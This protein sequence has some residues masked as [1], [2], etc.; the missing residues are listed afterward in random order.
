MVMVMFMCAPQCNPLLF[1]YRERMALW[2]LSVMSTYR[3]CPV[4]TTL[5]NLALNI[6]LN[7]LSANDSS[8]VGRHSLVPFAKVNSKFGVTKM[9]LGG[10][11]ED[12]QGSIL[13]F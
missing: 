12:L 8:V 4:A 3:F 1:S 6:I 10:N 5:A 13:R 7:L 2:K 11:D 9:S